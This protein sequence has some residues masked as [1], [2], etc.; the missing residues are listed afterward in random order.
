MLSFAFE[1]PG[2]E[3]GVAT[4]HHLRGAYEGSSF[5]TTAEATT[6]NAT[7]KNQRCNGRTW[8]RSSGSSW[9]SEYVLTHTSIRPIDQWAAKDGWAGPPINRA[10][11]RPIHQWAQPTHQ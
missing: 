2:D 11:G 8:S 3:S 9:W 4:Q 6:P 5:F 10:N 7:F 1:V